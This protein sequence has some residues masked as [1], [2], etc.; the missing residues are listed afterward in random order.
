MYDPSSGI[1]IRYLSVS[2]QWV[3]WWQLVLRD[4]YEACHSF[5]RTRTAL[6]LSKAIQ[7]QLKVHPEDNAA[8]V[9]K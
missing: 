6:K 1:R 8:L 9:Q 4:N 2:M 3:T 7:R 5:V